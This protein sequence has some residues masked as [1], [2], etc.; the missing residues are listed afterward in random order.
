[1]RA[2]KRLRSL[3]VAVITLL[4]MMSHEARAGYNDLRRE[5]DGY[6]PPALVA[7]Q[8]KPRAEAAA[9]PSS[10]SADEFKAQVAALHKKQLEWGKT[11]AK[12]QTTDSFLVPEA[13]LIEKLQPAAK[14]SAAAG[15]ALANGFTLQTLEALVLLRSPTIQA[16]ESEARAVLEGY[17]QAED[18]DTILRRYASFTKSLMTGVGGMSNPDPVTLKFPFPGVLALKGEV[19]GQEARAARSELETARREALTAIRRD[20]AELLYVRKA[21]DLTRSQLS[22]FDTLRGAVSTRYQAGTTS[23]QD[24]TSIDI[25]REKLRE[26]LTTLGEVKKNTEATIRDALV[27]PESV[28][29]G[30]PAP[31]LSA[32]GP[33]KVENLYA[34]ALERRQELQTQSAAIGRL[35]RMLELAETMIYPGYNQGLSL[36]EGDTISRVKGEGL[37]QGGN[38]DGSFST[39]G[40]AST[41]IGL[42]KMPW[43]GTDDA[44]LRQTRQRIASLKS[45]LEATRAATI[46][47]VREAW[48]QFDKARRQEALY[49]NRVTPLTKASLDSSGKGYAAGQ[50]GFKELIE[51]ATD[52]LGTNLALARAEADALI[53]EAELDA[54]VGVDQAGR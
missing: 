10:P 22:L 44:Y 8:L 17:G 20:H 53:A 12:P 32:R 48:F 7:S 27:L 35:E 38:E 9:P 15:K 23:F 30:T 28:V 33:V 51:S 31:Y 1:M 43:F 41:G 4:V 47:G 16:K 18:L 42:P 11:L 34:L 5:M 24:P 40:S 54:A 39:T 3:S 52:W 37:A 50:I 25:E 46:L 2:G 49:R 26:E 36:F 14:D 21:L 29:I 13:K 45:E 6:Q 19:V